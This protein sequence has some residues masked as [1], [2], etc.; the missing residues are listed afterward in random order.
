MSES[1]Y[2]TDLSQ[3]PCNTGHEGIYQGDAERQKLM[4][5]IEQYELGLG[6]NNTKDVSKASEKEKYV[7]PIEKEKQKTILL[8]G[9][10][11]RRW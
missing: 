11:I 7:S 5:I 9:S 4:R 1:E 6:Q 8:F 10:A 3:K 2:Y